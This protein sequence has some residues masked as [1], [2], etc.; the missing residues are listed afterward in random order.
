VKR[1][2]LAALHLLD[3]LMTTDDF[4]A[5]RPFSGKEEAAP[6]KKGPK[7]EAAFFPLLGLLAGEFRRV[8]AMKAALAQLPAGARPARRLDYRTFA[9]R[10]LPALKSPPRSGPQIPL[11]GH[12][13]VLHKA[14][15]ASSDWSLDELVEAMKGIAAIDEGVK[16]GTGD[17]RDLLETFLLSRATPAGGVGKGSVRG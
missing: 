6:A 14:Y 1:Q 15:L 16:T 7:G 10:L 5:F 12:P 9:D 13:F 8:L 11:E 17:G 2:F 3:R 4:T